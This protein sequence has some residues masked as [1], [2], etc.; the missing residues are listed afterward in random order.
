[1]DE[2]RTGRL[3]RLPT[4]QAPAARISAPRLLGYG[5]RVAA[6]AGLGV[7]AFVHATSAGLY[8]GPGGGFITEGSLFRAEAAV[9]VLLAALLLIR[10]AR[11]TWVAVL[12]V[13]GT[14]LGAVILYRYI[15]VGAI[16]PVPDLYEPTW[17]VPGKLASASAEAA[18]LVLSALALSG[19]RVASAAITR[20]LGKA[21]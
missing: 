11:L 20:V 21:G 2:S 9:S 5:L 8:D 13:A 3:V 1:M 17:R 15:D 14:A 19:G 7:D 18:V 16:G 6:A 10:P 4:A 12:A